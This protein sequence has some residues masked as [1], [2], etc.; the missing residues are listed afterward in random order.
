MPGFHDPSDL[1]RLAS[2]GLWVAELV[3]QRGQMVTVAEHVEAARKD[4]FV[5]CAWH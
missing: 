5:E 1:E 2:A 4:D 3:Y